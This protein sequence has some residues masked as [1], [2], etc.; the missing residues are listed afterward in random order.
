MQTLEKNITNFLGNKGKSW[1]AALPNITKKLAKQWSLSNI[2]PI[3]NMSWNYVAKAVRNDNSPVV[4]KISCDE[5]LI[6]SEVKALQH[7][8]GYGMVKLLAH[9]AEEHAVLLEQV[10]P[11][12][13]LCC[14]FPHR[15]EDVIDYYAAVVRQFISVPHPA[16][17]EFEHISSWLVA[18]D[19]ADKS[20]FPEG[21]LERALFLKNRLLATSKNELLLHGDLHHD[22]ILSD[23]KTCVAIDPKGVIGEIEF[24]VAWFDFIHDSELHRH[25]IPILFERRAKVLSDA[26][27]IN[28]QRLKDWVFVRLILSACWMVENNDDPSMVIKQVKRARNIIKQLRKKS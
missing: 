22:N 8:S 12:D 23:G 24:E 25:D 21:L 1:L 16:N 17:D 11:G 19:N 4:L 15:A 27:N 18:I 2:Q 13:S 10:L 28:F 3:D 6:C 26:L 20:K 9:N 7:F 14:I 5:K